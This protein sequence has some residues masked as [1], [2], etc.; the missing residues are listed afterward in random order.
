MRMV[1]IFAV[2]LLLGVLGVGACASHAPASPIMP[3]SC[4]RVVAI[5]GGSSPIT[6]PA[7][8]ILS[9]ACNISFCN[10]SPNQTGSNAVILQGFP[11][12]IVPHLY[13]GQCVTVAIAGE[14]W[15]ALATPG[16]FRPK[17]NP[18]LYVDNAGNDSNDGLTPATPLATPQRCSDILQTEYNLI[19]RQ[20]ACLLTGGQKFGP[21]KIVGPFVGTGAVNFNGVGGVATIQAVPGGNAGTIEDYAPYLISTNIDFSCAG[22]PSGCTSFFL[23]QVTGADL[24]DGT[25][26]T[27]GGVAD[28][29]IAC[30]SVA[31]V[32]V[33]SDGLAP[34][35]FAGSAAFGV[36][37]TLNCQIAFNKGIAL[38]S[39]ASIGEL[40]S[41]TGDA[42]LSFTG[43]ITAAGKASITVATVNM[44]GNASACF[45][46]LG[47]PAAVGT[48]WQALVFNGA[49]LVN[50]SP[51]PLPGAGV[52]T[53]Y[54]GYADGHAPDARGGNLGFGAPGC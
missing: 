32:N 52:V 3:A 44:S 16:L 20:P 9:G 48:A 42:S 53:S 37:G 26:L 14:E 47:A 11:D 4:G 5:P 49:V 17:F 29:L 19:T 41:I 28:T 30:D 10:N 36:N 35:T 7:S 8:R 40:L 23:H 33:S 21:V 25:I 43:Q 15:V 38:A 54:P 13:P 18:A 51:Y 2:A 34:V 24:N 46:G 50:L 27:G 39:G 6:L 22:I 1:R 12:P 31:K 45:S